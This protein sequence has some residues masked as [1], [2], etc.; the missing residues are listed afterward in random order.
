MEDGDLRR[1]AGHRAGPTKLARSS[2]YSRTHSGDGAKIR[3]TFRKK[4]LADLKEFSRGG[5]DLPQTVEAAAQQLVASLTETERAL[6][7]E[8]ADC[9]LQI[10]IRMEIRQTWQLWNPNSA[11]CF[12]A[13]DHHKAYDPDMISGVIVE[14]A[15]ELLTVES[16]GNI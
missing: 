5:H 12:D 13:V 1:Y 6:L 15:Q 8:R 11:L 10:G 4:S 9:A 3:K 2:R 14:A 7:R 16:V